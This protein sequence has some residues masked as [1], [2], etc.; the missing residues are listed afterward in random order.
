VEVLLL[1][2][3][4]A[5]LTGRKELALDLPEGT[6]LYAD[7]AYTDYDYKDQLQAERKIAYLPVRNSHLKSAQ[8]SETV[9]QQLSKTRRRIE[10]TFRQITARLARR[11]HAVTADCFE[12][13]ILATFVAYAI[14]GVAG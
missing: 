6:T 1:C 13:K 3:C 8:H 9:A 4:S 10:T 12:S 2:V 5:E 14:L 11:I 7:E